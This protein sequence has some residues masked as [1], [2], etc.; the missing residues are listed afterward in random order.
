MWKAGSRAF[1]RSA[2]IHDMIDQ[3]SYTISVVD[4]LAGPG[5]PQA[6]S[7]WAVRRP[8]R[9]TPHAPRCVME[10]GSVPSW[11]GLEARITIGNG[12]RI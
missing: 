7:Y 3:S 11:L 9:G 1:V 4:Q 5:E 10:M 6:L 12:W 2:Q 8:A